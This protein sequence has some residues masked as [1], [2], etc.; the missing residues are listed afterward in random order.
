MAEID[1]LDKSK[2]RR[3]FVKMHTTGSIQLTS[4]LAQ[5]ESLQIQMEFLAHKSNFLISESFH[6]QLE[7]S[8]CKIQG[9]C[10]FYYANARQLVRHYH[11]LCKTPPCDDTRRQ[12]WPDGADLTQKLWGSTKD[13][14]CQRGA[15]VRSMFEINISAGHLWG[16]GF[17][18]R[19]NPFLMW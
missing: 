9:L 6:I 1:H 17:D 7:F 5:F 11:T 12:I 2:T 4:I 15:V 13:L 19:S 8:T 10:S 14:S 3:A 16:R 18:S